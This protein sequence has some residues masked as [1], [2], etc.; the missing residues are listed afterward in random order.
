MSGTWTGDPGGGAYVIRVEGHLDPRWAAWF[1][2]LSI[3]EEGDGTSVLS[4]EVADQAA[5]HGLLD[6]VRDLGL[7]LVCVARTDG[8]RHSSD[9]HRERCAPNPRRTT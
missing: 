8:T 3:A 4:G 9:Q 2:G 1:D 7:P 6:R 5:L